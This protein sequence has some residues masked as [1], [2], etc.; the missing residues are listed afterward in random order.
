MSE[1]YVSYKYAGYVYDVKE[2]QFGIE[3][4]CRTV[5]DENDI[6][7]PQH[8]LFTVGSKSKHFKEVSALGIGI[9]DKV[10]IDFVPSLYEGVSKSTNKPFSI[11]KNNITSAKVVEKS[12]STVENLDGCEDIPF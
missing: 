8:I 7:Y 9:D 11:C 1:Q 10:E 4:K 2:E 5:K 3:I 12:S 6:K